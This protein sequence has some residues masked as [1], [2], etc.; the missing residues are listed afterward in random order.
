MPC[1]SN[2]LL[3][4]LHFLLAVDLRRYYRPG[5]CDILT[6]SIKEPNTESHMPI[7]NP[8]PA[9]Y[10]MDL[11]YQSY[12]LSR[13]NEHEWTMIYDSEVDRM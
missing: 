9:Q 7:L 1:E 4:S 8:S 11:D 13:H 3:G 2:E 10:I 6:N 12:T 5:C